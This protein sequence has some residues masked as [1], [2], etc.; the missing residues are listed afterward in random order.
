MIK[1]ETGYKFNN[2]NAANNAQSALR[3][4]YLGGRP[5]A[6]PEGYTTSEWVSVEFNDGAS[7]TFYY[8]LGNY[9]PVL[10]NATNFNIDIEEI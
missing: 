2:E 6:P 3:V 1:E 9:A 5:P 8:F 7:G 4:H 10:G